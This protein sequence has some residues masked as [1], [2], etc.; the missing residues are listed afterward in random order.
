MNI[1]V[2]SIRETVP[3]ADAIRLF[4]NSRITALPV[5]DREGHVRGILSSTDLISITN[6]CQ[7]VSD[8]FTRRVITVQRKSTL[9]RIIRLFQSKR[10]RC[11]PVVDDDE[12]LIGIIGRKEILAYYS[13]IFG[14]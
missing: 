3:C 8:V 10:I 4:L 7:K 5:L 14:L 6:Q 2:V 11:I 13:R 9:S 1:D 12:R